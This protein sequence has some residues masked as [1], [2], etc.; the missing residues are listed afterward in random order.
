MA[1]HEVVSHEA[2]LEA[3]KKHLMKEKEFTRLRDQLSAER[4]DLPWE[5]VAKEYAFEGERGRQ[6][7]GD[8]FGGRGMLFLLLRDGQLQMA[9]RSI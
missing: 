4:R 3:R 7:L 1:N 8:I 5:L 6:T 2:W 9:S